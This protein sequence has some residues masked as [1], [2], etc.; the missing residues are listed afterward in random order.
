MKTFCLT[1]SAKDHHE[2]KNMTIKAQE[3]EKTVTLTAEELTEM[4]FGG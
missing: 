4:Y 1:G 2:V 3:E